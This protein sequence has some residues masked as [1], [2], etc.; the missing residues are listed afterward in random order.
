MG[1][2]SR[3]AVSLTRWT[4][5]YI[6][7]ALSIAFILTVIVFVFGLIWGKAPDGLAGANLLHLIKYWG[8]G[9]WELL[10][11]AM[12]M[13]LI[14]VTGYIVAVSP[15]VSRFLRW[16][17]GIPR[18]GP[19]AVLTMALV[20]M[21]LAFLNW[22]LSLIASAIFVGF[23]AKKVRNVDYRLLVASA[24]F[25]MGA[26]WHAGLS[27]S[28][29][30]L[31]ATPGHFMES[32]MGVIPVVETI[33]SP[34]NLILVLVVVIVMAVVVF[35]SHPRK[36]EDTLSLNGDELNKGEDVKNASA[37]RLGRVSTFA[38]FWDNTPVFN[39]LFGFA[40]ITY[41]VVYLLTKPGFSLNLNILNFVFFFVG[42]ILYPSP[43]AF[44]RA[45]M[46]GGEKVYGVIIQFPL[47]A[48]MYGIIKSGGLAET[49]ANAFVTISSPK[50]FPLVVYW[51]SGI[52]N[53]FVPSGGSKWAIEAP[54]LVEAAKTLGVPLS[55]TV[56]SYAWGDM[57]TDLIQP[58]W[59]IPLL[60]IAKIEFGRI[61]GYL[62]LAFIVFAILTT[63][64]FWIY[65][66]AS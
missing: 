63:A 37:Y 35:L 45:A 7:S 46:A 49:F 40:G 56:L 65:G 29:P 27:A 3:I 15:P 61:M 13:A 39:L 14:I 23:I 50:T 51:Y 20:S 42:L 38:D 41:V 22:G 47:Y 53:Y 58:F 31:V 30:L 8:D 33:F 52:V 54:Y 44:S 5:K 10:S 21:A 24:Y 48:G 32:E 25:G 18:S 55:K 6:P 64:A 12:Q 2:L 4:E 34:F 36:G 62:M 59:A 11:F 17:A 57:A 1:I 26:V 9:F 60:S 19:S 43:Q 16:L 66:M 28:A